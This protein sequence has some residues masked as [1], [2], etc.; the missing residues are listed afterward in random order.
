MLTEYQVFVTTSDMQRS[1]L[2]VI[3]EV[4]LSQPE[5]IQLAQDKLDEIRSAVLGPDV[6]IRFGVDSPPHRIRNKQG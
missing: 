5:I 6:E 1:I 4:G 2:R 3:G